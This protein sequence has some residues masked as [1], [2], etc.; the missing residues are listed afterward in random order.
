MNLN[1]HYV[2]NKQIVMSLLTE[3]FRRVYLKFRMGSRG[4][5]YRMLV[6]ESADVLGAIRY[7]SSE[8][9]WECFFGLFAISF[10]KFK[11]FHLTA[12]KSVA[13]G[14]PIRLKS[15]SPACSVRKKSATFPIKRD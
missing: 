15:G 1:P 12:G 4:A 7:I 2:F 5:S 10:F 8:V 9:C 13:P 14:N 3:L 11:T 6:L